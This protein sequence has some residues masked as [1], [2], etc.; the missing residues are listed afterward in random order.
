MSFLKCRKKRLAVML[1]LAVLIGNLAAAPN[2]SILATE[3]GEEYIAEDTTV[4]EPSP[5]PEENPGELSQEISPIPTEEAEDA[6]EEITPVP[7]EAPEIT[8]EPEKEPTKAPEITEEPEKEPT[9]AP[10][11]TEE[12]EKEPTKAPEIMEE[13]AKE[14]TATPTPTPS[15]TP[16]IKPSA[17]IP[18]ESNDARY[19]YLFGTDV[20]E[21]TMDNRPPG[22]ATEKEA[23]TH[24]KTITVPVWKMDS[25]GGRYAS[26]F[27]LTINEKL[28]KNVKAIFQEIY[29]LDI[30][31]P[32]RVLKGYGYRKVGGVGLSNST[33]MSMHSFGAAI[34]I[35]PWD[36]DNDYYLGKGNDLRDK[37]NPY[38]IPDE[39]IEIF[40]RYGWYWGGEFEICADT[41]HFQYLGLE[42][43]TYQ[44]KSPFR[45]LKVKK[46]YMKGTDVRNLQQRL[47]ELG[48]SVSVDG[49]YG[50]KTAE[51]VKKYQ[52]KKGL[53][54]TGTVNY[55]TWETIINET[56]D[57][58]YAF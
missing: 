57:M 53:K 29:A 15:P 16:T 50:K 24:M 38:C 46:A 30:Q 26:S 33:L 18:T 12:P 55:K 54:V 32:I 6:P 35:N 21:L 44:D 8:E 39:V 47:R 31:F 45:N 4:L 25:K 28:A 2:A 23:A 10:E 27:K 17:Q 56:H 36:E 5:V 7:T 3:L 41:M 52:K 40:E 48:Y 42:Y 19:Q 37:S 14:P 49:V 22:Y 13:P 58:P 1:S 9:Q 20:I 34:D 51:A 43:L 11:I